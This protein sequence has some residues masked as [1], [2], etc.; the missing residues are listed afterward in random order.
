MLETGIIIDQ[1]SVFC[2]VFK[3]FF[4]YAKDGEV[5]GDVDSEEEDED[6]DDEED[7][8]ELIYSIFSFLSANR[9]NAATSPTSFSHKAPYSL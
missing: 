6:D 5:N 7:D 4:L 8:G 3:L 2:Y 1:F 9:T